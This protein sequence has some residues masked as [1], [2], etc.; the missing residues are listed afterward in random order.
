MAALSS[1]DQQRAARLLARTLF[2]VQTATV[3]HSDLV[4][5]VAAVDGAMEGL[6]AALPN[7]T[8]SVA[9]NLN[10]SLPEPVKST[11]TTTQKSILLAVWA[12]VKYGTL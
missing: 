6:P 10:T 9:V 12:G 8:Q 7:P 11:L 1:T 2:H 5:A 3:H 4:A